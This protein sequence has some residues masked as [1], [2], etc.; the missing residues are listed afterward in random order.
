MDLDELPL[1]IRL[2]NQPVVG[3]VGPCTSGKSTLVDALKEYGVNAR[4]IAQEHSASPYMWHKVTQPDVLIY[5]D[6]TLQ[7][8]T[9][10]R[11]GL[12]NPGWLDKQRVRLAHAYQHADL[13]IMTA[14][15]SPSQIR[16]EVLTFLNTPRNRE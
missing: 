1:S 2:A 9:E 16:D 7:V 6:V 3:V 11:P 10:R 4:H 8:A 13:Y 12:T 14:D 5:L 15:K